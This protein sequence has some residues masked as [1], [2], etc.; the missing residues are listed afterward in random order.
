MMKAYRSHAG[1]VHLQRRD[2]CLT[3]VAHYAG[4]H[5]VP[6]IVGG[7][8]LWSRHTP[9]RIRRMARHAQRQKQI[10]ERRRT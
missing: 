10:L 9:R 5:E 1:I 7:R 4:I 6:V 8:L 2:G 3:I